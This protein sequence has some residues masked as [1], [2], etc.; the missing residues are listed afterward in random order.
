MSRCYNIAFCW[1]NIFTCFKVLYISV[2]LCTET[3]CTIVISLSHQKCNS[4]IITLH[5][6]NCYRSTVTS[7][8]FRVSRQLV[9]KKSRKVSK[10]YAYN[11]GQYLTVWRQSRSR[12]PL[13]QIKSLC[14]Y[15]RLGNIFIKVHRC[16]TLPGIVQ[17]NIYRMWLSVACWQLLL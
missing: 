14:Y 6:E 12:Y 16:M 10:C 8:K 11:I 9:P 7:V 4:L 17:K 15:C 2:K 1:T 3:P 5:L 13:M